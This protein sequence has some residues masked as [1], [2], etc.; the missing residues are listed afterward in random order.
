MDYLKTY[1]DIKND[2][3][4][5][6]I[7]YS[8]LLN[9]L[10]WKEKRKLIIHRENNTCQICKNR[11]AD[12]YILIFK[13]NF[14]SKVPA[15][16]KE[17]SKKNIDAFGDD[18]DSISLELIEQEIPLIA[19]VHHTYYVLNKLPWEYP[20]GDLMLVCHKCHTEI[21]ETTEINIYID[22]KNGKTINLTHCKKCKGSGYLPEYNYYQN[23]LCFSCGGSCYEEWK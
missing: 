17:V 22:N 16:I 18:F 2:Y 14:V 6:R 20:N 11:C 12:D 21:H 8:V 1:L 10:E 23:G 19:H 3:Q 5:K 15:V 13:G 7:P 9:T 4:K